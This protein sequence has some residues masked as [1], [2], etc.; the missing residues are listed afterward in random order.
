MAKY[1][2]ATRGLA[3]ANEAVQI[4]GGIGLTR[5]S[6]VERIL[7]DMRIF[8]VGEGTNE[9]QKN[10]IARRESERDPPVKAPVV[11]EMWDDPG[12]RQ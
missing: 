12:G 8:S 10:V 6:H 7:R 9:M 1:F 2:S 4:H 3:V 11:E 5:K